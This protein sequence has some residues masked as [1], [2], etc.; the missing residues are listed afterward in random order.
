MSKLNVLILVPCLLFLS[1]SQ[2]GVWTKKQGEAYKQL[3]FTYIR[4]HKLF[5]E[6]GETIVLPRNVRD[7]TLQAYMEYGLTDKFTLIAVL[8]Y[9]FIGTEAEIFSTNQFF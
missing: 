6:N 5:K 8:P 9:K 4:S 1:A 3:S 7:Y 2:A